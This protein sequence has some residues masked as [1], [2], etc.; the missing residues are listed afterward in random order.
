[1]DACPRL[2][3]GLAVVN[4]E[5]DVAVALDTDFQ[6]LLGAPEDD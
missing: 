4:P 3:A 2:A 1:M 5:R 6:I